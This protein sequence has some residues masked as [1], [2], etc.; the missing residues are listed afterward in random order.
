MQA[1]GSVNPT[2]PV[3]VFW[4]KKSENNRIEPLTGIQKRLSYGI[5]S[6]EPVSQAR[7]EWM[8]KL[9]AY[10]NR[11]FIMKRV[12]GD[13]YKVFIL[14]GN[15][16]VEVKKMHVEFDGGSFLSPSIAYVE[17]TGVDHSSG[18]AITEIIAGSD[19]HALKEQEVF[20]SSNQ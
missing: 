5:K 14:S 17:L 19:R 11:E 3:K 10:R 2:K 16:K 9:A 12:N 20:T 4:V 13:Q 6:L 8:F 1:D 7:D 18:L 15:R